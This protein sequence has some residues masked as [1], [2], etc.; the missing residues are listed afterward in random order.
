M[1]NFT[2]LR[3]I[4][5]KFD[6]LARSERGGRYHKESVCKAYFHTSHDV[7]KMI[8]VTEVLEGWTNDW[9]VDPEHYLPH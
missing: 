7:A 9:Y 5:K 3:K 8:G 2:G 6:K 1:L 4:L